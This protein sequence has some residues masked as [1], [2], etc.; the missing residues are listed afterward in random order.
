MLR[1]R[2]GVLL[3]RASFAPTN[4]LMTLDFPTLERPRKAISGTPG[5]RKCDQQN[6]DDRDGDDETRRSPEAESR[7]AAGFRFHKFYF[8]AGSQTLSDGW[9]GFFIWQRNVRRR[10]SEFVWLLLHFW[11]LTGWVLHSI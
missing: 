4:E 1:V 7:A 9:R 3:V 11:M 10:A 6:C 8:T 5:G 2:P